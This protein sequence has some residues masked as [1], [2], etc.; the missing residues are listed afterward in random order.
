MLLRRQHPGTALAELEVFVEMKLAARFIGCLGFAALCAV[1]G[2]LA[3][4]GALTGLFRVM[5]CTDPLQMAAESC[6]AG[7]WIGGVCGW[8][9]YLRGGWSVPGVAVSMS[10]AAIGATVAFTVASL[11]GW[12]AANLPPGVELTVAD[13]LRTVESALLGW[14]GGAV[15]AWFALRCV[16]PRK[17]AT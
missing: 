12:G 1:A 2:I 8:R 5:G 9:A 6:G 17:V 11:S 16:I 4:A 13:M 3:A 7:A 15:V 14:I 10:V